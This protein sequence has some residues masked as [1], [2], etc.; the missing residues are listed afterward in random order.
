LRN[1]GKSF[2]KSGGLIRQ[3]WENPLLLAKSKYPQR[4]VPHEKQRSKCMAMFKAVK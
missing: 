4:I 2:L 1:E 3:P